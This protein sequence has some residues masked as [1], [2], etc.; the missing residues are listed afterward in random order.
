MKPTVRTQL[1]QGFLLDLTS[2]FGLY[3][4]QSLCQTCL[5]LLASLPIFQVR[6]HNYFT[7]P[8]NSAEWYFQPSIHNTY[9]AS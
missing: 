7:F 8:P 5:S 1:Y 6:K 4:A 3:L 9:V 2:T